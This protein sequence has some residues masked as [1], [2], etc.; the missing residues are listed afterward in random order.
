MR[1]SNID[2]NGAQEREEIKRTEKKLGD[3]KNEN[4]LELI[5][6]H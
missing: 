5:K 6:K 2:L 1:R 4:F 3:I